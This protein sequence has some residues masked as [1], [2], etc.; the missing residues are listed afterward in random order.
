MIGEPTMPGKWSKVAWGVA[1]ATIGAA[2][3]GAV[4]F[5][6]LAP[7]YGVGDFMGVPLNVLLPFLIGTLGFVGVY[8]LKPKMG[9]TVQN[10]LTFGSAAAIGFGVAQYAGWITPAVTT[11]ARARTYVPPRVTAPVI[12][13]STANQGTKMI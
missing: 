4:H 13:T 3:F 8:A 2:A 6:F 12:M 7:Q 5:M 10:I 9:E 1:A 11:R